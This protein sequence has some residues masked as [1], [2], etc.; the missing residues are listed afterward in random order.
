[1]KRLNEETMSA[2]QF[3][4]GFLF[5]LYKPVKHKAQF[6]NDTCSI[7]KRHLFIYVFIS[8]FYFLN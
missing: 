5:C 8:R 4:G 1:M 6:N 3:S 7:C 2:V